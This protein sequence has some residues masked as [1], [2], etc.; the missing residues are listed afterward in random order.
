MRESNKLTFHKR[1]KNYQ[2]DKQLIPE[3]TYLLPVVHKLIL[4][5]IH[6]F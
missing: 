5:M 2:C 3:I 1:T 4:S 6:I